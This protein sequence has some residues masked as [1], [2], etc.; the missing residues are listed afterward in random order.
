[1]V[2]KEATNA[3]ARGRTIRLFRCGISSAAQEVT[4]DGPLT[5]GGVE[6]RTLTQPEIEG[7]A[8]G[9]DATTANEPPLG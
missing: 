5:A 4:E 9:F 8:R 2:K 7:E 3:R 6:G 1:M